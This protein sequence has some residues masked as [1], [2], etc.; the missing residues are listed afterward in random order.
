MVFS[1]NEKLKTRRSDC[2]ENKHVEETIHNLDDPKGSFGIGG[3]IIIII[4]R[5]HA[6]CKPMMP[7]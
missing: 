2:D 6:K 3:A 4:M 5:G 1:K 7:G